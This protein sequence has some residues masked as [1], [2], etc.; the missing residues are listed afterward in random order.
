MAA[1]TRRRAMELV[2]REPLLS[3]TRLAGRLLDTQR[4]H[5]VAHGVARVNVIG[6][7]RMGGRFPLRETTPKGD[8]VAE[9][10]ALLG[11]DAHLECGGRRDHG[12]Q[13]RHPAS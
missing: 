6:G 13:G 5:T 7:N 8:H 1:A 9:H 11:H 2:T 4:S 12:A 10:L 3:A